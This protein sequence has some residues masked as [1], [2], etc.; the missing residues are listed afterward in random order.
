MRMAGRAFVGLAPAVPSLPKPRPALHRGFR[1]T[2]A[3]APPA[4]EDVV[5][6][7]RLA[8]ASPG[9]YIFRDG[10]PPSSRALYVGKARSLRARIRSYITGASAP[11]T[12]AMIA[13]AR[14][15][16]LLPTETEAAALAL[17]AS[18]V[19]ELRPPYN[20]LLKDD[21]RHPYVV[22]TG[23]DFPRLLTTR[24]VS[25]S[26]RRPAGGRVYGPFVDEG[27]LKRV[28][29]ALSKAYPLR[30][31]ATP[32]HADRP[33]LNYSMGTCSGPCQGLVTKEAYAQYARQVGMLLAGRV[34]EVLGEIEAGM[35]EAVRVLDFEAAAVLRDRRD[36][37]RGAF[38]LVDGDGG[39]MADEAAA[40]A[41]VNDPAVAASTSR[42]VVACVTTPD[43]ATAKVAL[44]QVRAGSVVNRL[45]FSASCGASADPALLP[46]EALAATLADHYGRAEHRL[47]LPEEVVLATPMRSAADVKLLAA[48]LSERR[49][50]TVRVVPA[51]STTRQIADIALRNAELE[52]ALDAARLDARR[53]ELDS[54]A[55]L[56]APRWPSLSSSAALQRIESYD[57]SHMSGDHAVG[58]M[59]VLLG[60]AP[61]PAEYRRF[62]LDES[63]SS[64][65]TPDDCASIAATLRRRFSSTSS[66]AGGPSPGLI[67]IDGGKGQLSA[68]V[69][70]LAHLP[71]AAGIPVV[72]L[73]KRNEE[74]YLPGVGPAINE[75]VGVSAGVRLLCRAR[76][77]AHRN[78]VAS[79]RR[80]HGRAMLRSG[81]DGVP[82]IGA[83]KRE[84]L[85]RHFPGGATAIAVASIEAL[86]QTPGIGRR[87]AARVYEHYH[88]ARAGRE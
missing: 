24:R 10:P 54:L 81:L 74:L 36:V 15:L 20:V 32:L 42:D 1:W 78:G 64:L 57:V 30:Q 83:S 80:L 67:L 17:E 71:A 61:A 46:G 27:R 44:V 16:E 9:V 6:T 76:D 53:A 84:A 65:G 40:V 85:L 37:V 26:A 56:L 41:S 25:S 22:L 77:E 86:A 50:K 38:T 69:D 7:A 39:S 87:A 3:A 29:D 70:A 62:A 11:R 4:S 63:A 55:D 58:S 43:G 51:G 52:A 13:E 75:K 88:S 23:G 31:R 34:A 2:A 5:Q 19:R 12:M 59:A 47:E 35:A 14:S 8:P 18:L 73:A 72:S 49:A 68:A 21:R 45:L 48:V 82:G 33:C 66:L 28:C 79:T 60:G